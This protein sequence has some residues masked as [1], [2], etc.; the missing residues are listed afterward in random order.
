[1]IETNKANIIAEEITENI[2]TAIE[3][4]LERELAINP[5]K[6]KIF[7]V[8]DNKEKPFAVFVTSNEKPEIVQL[9]IFVNKKAEDIN[10]AEAVKGIPQILSEKYPLA[11]KIRIQIKDNEGIIKRSLNEFSVKERNIVYEKNLHAAQKNPELR[12]ITAKKQKSADMS[13]ASVPTPTGEEKISMQSEKS[14]ETRQKPDA[15]TAAGAIQQI[16]EV[17]TTEPDIIRIKDTSETPD[18]I[19]PLPVINQEETVMLQE[20]TIPQ[21]VI[22][23]SKDPKTSNAPAKINAEDKTIEITTN[24]LEGRLEKNFAKGLQQR[25]D[26]FNTAK[27]LILFYLAGKRISEPISV[28]D[29]LN[30]CNISIGL[31]ETFLTVVCKIINRSPDEECRKIMTIEKII[32]KFSGADPETIEISAAKKQ[33]PLPI[34]TDKQEKP[35]SSITAPA[36]SIA[37]AVY[38]PPETKKLFE[39]QYAPDKEEKD[40]KNIQEKIDKICKNYRLIPLQ[41]SIL[42]ALTENPLS[43]NEIKVKIKKSGELKGQLLFLQEN[44]LITAVRGGYKLNFQSG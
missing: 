38:E 35:E 7:I 44:R 22:E 41:K 20:D 27:K 28:A 39:M 31:L 16:T 9:H 33:A 19:V 36:K 17:N 14:A 37:L 15:E 3:I 26:Q 21:P 34:N 42:E 1:M 24:D 13:R 10:L 2:S 43:E 23:P 11:E 40:P 29:L 4:C 8:K 18:K 25:P 5:K 32:I 30:K 12:K 6:Q